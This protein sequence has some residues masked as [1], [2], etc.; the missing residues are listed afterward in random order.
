MRCNRQRPSTQT[1][2]YSKKYQKCCKAQ[3]V[4]NA[5]QYVYAVVQYMYCAVVA[6][7]LIVIRGHDGHRRKGKH[8]EAFSGRQ[9]KRLPVT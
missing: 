8:L 1:R 5:V 4:S 2:S 7:F 9:K 3:L 6:V